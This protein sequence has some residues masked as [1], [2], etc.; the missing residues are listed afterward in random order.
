MKEENIYIYVL[1]EDVIDYFDNNHLFKNFPDNRG[2]T[3]LG[4]KTWNFIF[5]TI[6]SHSQSYNFQNNYFSK[7]S[8]DEMIEL[9]QP[10]IE[11]YIFNLEKIA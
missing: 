10:I 11:K 3:E 7:L 4:L 9:L 1:M 8:K 2:L 6:K 5:D